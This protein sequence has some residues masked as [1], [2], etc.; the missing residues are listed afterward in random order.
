MTSD[1]PAIALACLLTLMGSI[2]CLT[3]CCVYLILAWHEEGTKR[4][5]RKTDDSDR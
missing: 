3:M 2:F 1:D 5:P 4:R